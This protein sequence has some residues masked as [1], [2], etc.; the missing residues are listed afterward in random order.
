MAMPACGRLPPCRLKRLGYEVLQASDG[1]SAL[2]ILKNGDE[3]DLL[4]T[5]IGLPGGL[6]GIELARLARDRDPSLRVLF[7]SGYTDGFAQESSELE[8]G[9]QFLAKTFDQAAFAH[10]VR[11]ALG[12]NPQAGASPVEDV[13]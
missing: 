5:D 13:A 1:A 7:V 9:V 2:S 3:T 10:S 12:H 11:T 8:P 6:D 4:L